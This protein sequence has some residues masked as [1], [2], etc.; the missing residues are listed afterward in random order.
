M[1]YFD[2]YEL[3]VSFHVDKNQVKKKFYELSKKYHPDRF[4]QASEEEQQE[5]LQMAALNNA[6]YK[7][8]SD[9]DTTM[10]YILKQESVLEEEEKY[11]LPPDFLMEMMELNEAVSEYEDDPTDKKKQLAEENW[12][13]QMRLIKE[14]TN[15][16]IKKYEV[17]KSHAVLTELK[18]FY[19]RKK[20]LLR[21]QERLVTFAAR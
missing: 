20:Y 14:G 3:P 17:S 16:L 19:F 1:N 4:S 10:R 21:I 8:L 15:V 13:A 7:T 9:E 6:A 5:V 18:D 2:L 11:A 12:K